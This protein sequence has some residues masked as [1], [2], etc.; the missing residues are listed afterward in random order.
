MAAP[1]TFYTYSAPSTAPQ[2]A[3]L[4]VLLLLPPPIFTL[5]RELPHHKQQPENQRYVGEQPR[6]IRGRAASTG[7]ETLDQAASADEAPSSDGTFATAAAAQD[8]L[9]YEKVKKAHREGHAA[10]PA[11]LYSAVDA[12]I[13]QQHAD[14]EAFCL[15]TGISVSAFRTF[16]R[17][18]EDHLKAGHKWTEFQGSDLLARLNGGRRLTFSER[19]VASEKWDEVKA[20]PT[21]MAEFEEEHR[22][23][24][25][26][27]AFAAWARDDRDR[28]QVAFQEYHAL[29]QEQAK[30]AAALN[31]HTLSFIISSVST[32]TLQACIATRPAL[33]TA[34]LSVGAPITI[35][36][37]LQKSMWAADVIDELRQE[38]LRTALAWF[39][40]SPQPEVLPKAAPLR[41]LVRE[42]YRKAFS[43]A[44][45]SAAARH[46]FD[47]AAVESDNVRWSTS[48]LAKVAL[49]LR[50]APELE[51]GSEPFYRNPRSSG[52]EHMVEMVKA[53]WADKIG[54]EVLDDWT[55]PRARAAP[56]D[57]EGEENVAAGSKRKGSSG[58]KEKK[59]GK[60]SR[61]SSAS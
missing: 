34:H 22:A 32:D 7:N 59:K 6:P 20:D 37:V 21:L 29:A 25:G 31:I 27:L 17:G 49:R 41:D 13:Q 51:G 43:D 45:T 9:A 15:R 2:G 26:A 33:A 3:L 1:N 12:F 48:K 10:V 11:K 18:K 52:Q 24:K 47:L 53:I 54:Y 35:M 30:A 55:A 46:S 14:V 19:G 50:L 60:K 38:K 42:L 61:T 36:G 5:L 57:D 23:K 16:E 4:R 56:S 8:Q 58:R 39:D 44:L 28:R 40:I